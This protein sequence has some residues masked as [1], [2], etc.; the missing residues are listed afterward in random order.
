M[1]R[2]LR[3]RAGIGPGAGV[4]KRSFDGRLFGQSWETPFVE[5]P[6]GPI[7]PDTIPELIERFHATYERRYG[8]RFEYVPVEGVSYRVELVIASE[9][10]SFTV[11]EATGEPA[12]PPRRTV[13]LRHLEGPKLAAAEYHRDTLPIGAQVRGPAVIREGLSTTLVCPS[14]VATVGA[15]GELVIE[16]EA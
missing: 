14:Q 9:K 12:P 8:N 1:E 13:E 11:G 10:I 6:D 15:F 7:E 4:V 2:G 5:L 3:E 16:R